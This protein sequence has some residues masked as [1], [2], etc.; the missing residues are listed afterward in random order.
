MRLL[1]T[2]VRL[3]P[4]IRRVSCYTYVGM[5]MRYDFLNMMRGRVGSEGVAP[6]ELQRMT[7]RLRQMSQ[8]GD[9]TAV[10]TAPRPRI[11]TAAGRFR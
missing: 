9:E 5:T 3:T 11:V 8:D 6:E 4:V 10:I 1:R 7:L 2:D